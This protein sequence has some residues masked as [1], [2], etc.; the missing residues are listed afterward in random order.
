MKVNCKYFHKNYENTIAKV[1][2][3]KDVIINIK[4]RIIDEIISIK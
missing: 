2:Y 3:F 1:F 4:Q